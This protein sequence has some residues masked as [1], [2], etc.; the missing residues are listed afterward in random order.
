MVSLLLSALPGAA[1]VLS[2][3]SANLVLAPIFRPLDAAQ[4][5]VEIV[6]VCIA[7]LTMQPA[8][9]VACTKALLHGQ[10]VH[11]MERSMTTL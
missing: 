6:G 4:R 5:T 9:A 11:I 7:V 3:L 1:Q 8:L 2:G 10:I